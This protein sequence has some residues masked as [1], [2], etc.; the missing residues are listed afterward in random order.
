VAKVILPDGSTKEVAPDTALSEVAAA[1]KGRSRIVAAQVNGCLVDLASPAPAEGEVRLIPADSPE[2]L[3][4]LRHSASHIMAQAVCRLRPGVRLGIGPAVEGGFYYELDTAITPGDLPAIEAE[5]RRII[6]ENQPF[7]R[8]ELSKSD[9]LQTMRD[10]G[11]S[12]KV[13]LIERL[14]DGQAISFYRNGEFTD[15][16]RGPH[17]PSTG[18]IGAFKLT[19]VAGHYW[20]GNETRPMLSSVWGVA[21]ADEADLQEYLKQREEAERRDHRKLGKQLDLFSMHEEAPGSPFWHPK[22]MILFNNVVNWWRGVLMA[23]NYCELRTPMILKQELWQRSGH[24]DHYRDNM[25]FT[26]ADDEPMVIKP[27]NCPGHALV[28]KTRL[29]SYRELPLRYAEMGVVHR[30]EKAGVLHGL[31]RVRHITQDDA[32]IF[33]MPQQIG[34]E[35]GRL[36]E[37]AD[38]AYST[39][40]MDYALELS[41]RPKNSMGSDELWEQAT[42]AL[43]GALE[44]RDLHYKVNEGDGAFY[45]PKIDFHIRDAIGRSWQC[46]TIQLDLVMLPERFDLTYAAADGTEHRPVVIHRTILGAI[47]RFIGILIEHYAGDFPL[48]LAPEQARVL[49][50]TDAH[51]EYGRQLLDKLRVAGIR[52]TLDERNEKT[53]AK[54]RQATLEKV[55]YMLVVGDREVAG[56]TVSVRSKKAGQVGTMPVDELIARLNAEI[57][58]KE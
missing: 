5:M 17:V 30:H 12:Y 21:F 50:I 10:A 43:R 22:G 52:V 41:T 42:S 34:E 49:P 39:F 11:Q 28:Y 58:R 46:A 27:M 20:L 4:V 13:E 15:L 38:Y 19:N 24:L 23:N 51:V 44:R 54:I 57:E 56:G 53:G 47:E 16:C 9:A 32:H 55:P 18:A 1:C 6:E 37:M 3:Q 29:H 45:G 33:L 26:R 14:E 7:V 8:R 2:G 48:W 35:V 40:G 36:I 31:M 25:Y